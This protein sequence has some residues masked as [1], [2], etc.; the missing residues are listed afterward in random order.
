LC[1]APCCPLGGRDNTSEASAA[2]SEQVAGAGT[3]ARPYDAD[4]V[5]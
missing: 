5:A 2:V 1:H 4:L 3:D